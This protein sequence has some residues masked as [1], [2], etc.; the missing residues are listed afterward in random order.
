M[1]DHPFESDYFTG[2]WGARV[3]NKGFVQLPNCLMFC[4]NHL[5]LTDA[6]FTVLAYLLTRQFTPRSKPYMSVKTLASHIGKGESATRD[7]LRKLEQKGFIVR[8][9]RK[10]DTN[11]YDLSGL[12]KKLNQHLPQC[13]H[14]PI[15]NEAARIR[16]IARSRYQKSDSKEKEGLRK[17]SNKKSTLAIGSVMAELWSEV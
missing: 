14:N 3:A 2:K 5:H 10:S 13:T 7:N 11:R 4:K 9:A 6:E 16:K 17:K 15:N 1:T 8:E 12:V